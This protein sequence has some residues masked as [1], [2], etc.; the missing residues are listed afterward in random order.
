MAL[1]LYSE[2]LQ[3]NF[4]DEGWKTDVQKACNAALIDGFDLEQIYTD[5]NPE[6]FI[7]NGVR[8]GV[9]RRF[10]HNIAEWAKRQ[11]QNHSVGLE[12]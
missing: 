2:W 1:R 12:E 6:F 3:S 11:T 9:A 8:K 5:Q 10:I 7:L 4:T